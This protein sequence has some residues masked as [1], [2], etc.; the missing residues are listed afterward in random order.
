VFITHLVFAFLAALLFSVLIA[1]LVGW[2]H[3]AHRGEGIV[4]PVLFVFLIL[5]LTSW[6]AGVWARPFGPMLWGTP[7]IPY[8]L[9]A[10]FVGLVLLA[11]AA[12]PRRSAAPIE[13]AEP[14]PATVVFGGFFWLL[15]ILLMV[16]IVVGYLG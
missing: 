4:G 10:L 13:K 5:F 14:S 11:I 2:R 15:V 12:P 7:W 1:G 9:A 8:F 6:V 16:A 3:P